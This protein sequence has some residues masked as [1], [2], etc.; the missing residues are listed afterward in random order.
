MS[1]SDELELPICVYVW[2]CGCLR[3]QQA[4]E[5][6]F[7]RQQR[8]KFQ[9]NLLQR[10]GNDSASADSLLHMSILAE[11]QRQ[12]EEEAAADEAAAAEARL[13]DEAAERERIAELEIQRR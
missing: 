7:A 11:R 1:K 3:V 6:E 12:E 8:R 5:E 10:D 9:D 2:V 13:Q 4:L